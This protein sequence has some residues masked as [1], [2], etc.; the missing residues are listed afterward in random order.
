MEELLGMLLNWSIASPQSVG[1]PAWSYMSATC[2]LYGR[3][4]HQ[5]LD[6]RPIGLIATSWGG[7][8]IEDWMP[9]DAIQQCN[10]ST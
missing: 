6:G 9:P 4:I 1:G 10:T 5:G 8:P 3:M 7:T 2:W